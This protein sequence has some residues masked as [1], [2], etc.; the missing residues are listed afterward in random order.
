[1]THACSMCYL[2]LFQKQQEFRH[3]MRSPQSGFV[4]AWLHPAEHGNETLVIPDPRAEQDDGTM[5]RV[6]TTLNSE[7]CTR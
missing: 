2:F 7:Q 6:C 4:L 3:V 5:D 1:M